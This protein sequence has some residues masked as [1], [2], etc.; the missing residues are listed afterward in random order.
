MKSATTHIA[1]AESAGAI[2]QCYE[3]MRELRPHLAGQ[4]DFVQRVQRQQQEGY[5]LAF[6]E[7]EAA[8]RA[9]A[10]Y[11]ILE[12]LF[13][14]RTLYVDDLVTRAADRSRGFGGQLFDWLVEEARREKCRAFTLDSNVQ[15]FG[16]HRFYLLKRMKIA[17]HHFTLDLE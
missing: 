9:V 14:G 13:S 17:A 1:V 7:A 5:R 2:A 16:A 12:L 10:G 15:R 3:V 6:V 11:R 8:V 4:D